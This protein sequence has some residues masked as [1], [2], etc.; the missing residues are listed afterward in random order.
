[1]NSKLLGD[2]MPVS[3]S[4]MES[5]VEQ[6]SSQLLNYIDKQYAVGNWSIIDRTIDD[7]CMSGNQGAKLLLLR[8][9]ALY[10]LGKLEEAKQ[11]VNQALTAGI[12]STEVSKYLIS[13]SYF[14]LAQLSVIQNDTDDA[15]ELFSLFSEVLNSE[16][17]NAEL[18]VIRAYNKYGYIAKSIYSLEN[19]LSSKECKHTETINA[20]R[21]ELRVVRTRVDANN[22]IQSISPETDQDRFT[23][24]GVVEEAKLVTTEL[25]RL[26][27]LNNELLKEKLSEPAKYYLSLF[28]ATEF[29]ERNEMHMAVHFLN[30]AAR[31]INCE[32]IM[33]ASHFYYELALQALKFKKGE[34][35]L[36][37]F[38]NS[39]FL[40][41]NIEQ[42]Q[43]EILS[44]AYQNIRSASIKKQ[45]HGHDLLIDYL[46]ENRQQF[47]QLEASLIMVEIGTT[48]EDIP[49]Q[50]STLQLANLCQELGIKFITVDMDPNN[51]LLAKSA[52]SA[53]ELNAKAVNQKGEDFLREFSSR[54]DFVF[55]DAYDFDHGMHSE[56]RQS[57]YKKYLGA[58][59]DEEK[60]HQMHLDCAKS[61]VEKLSDKGV[62]C[63]DDTWQDDKG[64]WTAKGTTAVPFLL[65]SGFEIIEARNRA[66]LMRRKAE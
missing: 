11:L 26:E 4:F 31:H 8:G 20:L 19:R 1:M 10:N 44:S 17:R 63:I 2:T 9:V 21:E 53:Q 3:E 14:S 59:I 48:R 5:S 46:K 55:L 66:V 51:S 29:A 61:L 32:N 62:I 12:S 34:L 18:C 15:T 57:R 56:L 45:Q 27:F 50:G 41:P 38:I 64:N 37:F 47:Q 42:N 35:A 7:D 40:S 28:A 30:S 43:R 36:D 6:K 52:F 49:G 22:P 25:E 54:L 23:A 16:Y 24:L 33:N 39:L 13:S 60:C 58:S 65:K